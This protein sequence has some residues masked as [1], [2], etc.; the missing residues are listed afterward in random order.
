MFLYTLFL[1]HFISVLI[2]IFIGILSINK[3][4]FFR[5]HNLIPFGFIFFGM[6]S[7]FE[8]FDHTRTKWLYI[9]HSSIFNWLFYSFISLGLAFLT[10][11]ISKN[12]LL[13]LSNFS[14]SFCSIISYWSIGKSFSLF[15][16]VLLS[17]FLIV[18]WYQRFKDWVLIFYPLFGIFFTIFFG[19]NLSISGNQIWHLFIG[20]SGTLSVISF[21]LVLIRSK[22]KFL[23]DK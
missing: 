10:T 9:D 23:R 22:K 12:K 6:A 16:Q 5:S 14:L 15:F 8:M 19:I 17:I 4:N 7:I 13:F 20:P 18:I 2:P 3:F 11:S 21:Y 1:A